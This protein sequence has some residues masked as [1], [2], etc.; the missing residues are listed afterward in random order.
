MDAVLYIGHGSRVKAGIDQAKR[1]IS[2]CMETCRMPIQ[3][4]CFLELAEPDIPEGIRRCVQRG[5]SRII[6]QPVLL[7]AAGHIKKDIPAEIEKA[8]KDY[9]DITFIYSHPFGVHDMIIDILIERIQEQGD[10]FSDDAFVL[11][12]G[13]GSSDPCIKTDFQQIKQMVEGRGITRAFPCY[14]A[15]ADPSFEEGLDFAQATGY[16]KIFVVP[17]LLFTGILMKEM[18]Q[19]IRERNQGNQSFILCQSLG[20]HAK[21]KKLLSRRIEESIRSNDDEQLSYHA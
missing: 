17:Y 20:Y 2:S 14:L 18:E 13:R 1:F 7:L 12:V 5:A 16:K 15:A 11:L 4:I 9:P 8:A 6:I 19:T 3:E 10:A 21:L